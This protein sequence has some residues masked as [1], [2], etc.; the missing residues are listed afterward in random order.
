VKTLHKS[1]YRPIYKPLHRLAQGLCCLS[2]SPAN[3]SRASIAPLVSGHRI[4]GKQIGHDVH[5]LNI[6]HP[7]QFIGIPLVSTGGVEGCED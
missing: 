1:I 3:R 6:R 4:G 2:L 7:L 5:H